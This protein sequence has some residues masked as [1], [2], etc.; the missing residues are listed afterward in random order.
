MTGVQTCALPI[1]EATIYSHD[2]KK[3]KTQ[4]EQAGIEV[5]MPSRV[6]GD[7]VNIAVLYLFIGIIVIS[8]ICLFFISYIILSR[9]YASKTNEYGIMRTLGLIKKRLD[10]IVL[11]ENVGIGMTSSILSLVLFVIVDAIYPIMRL[12]NYLSWIIIL[13]YFSIVFLF[14][15][16]IARRFN[17]RLFKFSVN[18]TLK[19][20]VARND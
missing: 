8:L 14:S 9:I 17:R 1:Y 5:T 3:T 20:E 2:I 10:K 7:Q 13:V 19:G 15:L 4:L 6:N 18:T 11:L 12:G 16:L